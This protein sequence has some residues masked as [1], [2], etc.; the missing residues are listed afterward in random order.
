MIW[1]QENLGEHSE[2]G[3]GKAAYSE[4]GTGE[5]TGHRH[6][7]GWAVRVVSGC[8]SI[9]RAV[10]NWG[11][12]GTSWW[13]GGTWLPYGEICPPLPLQEGLAKVP[14]A[15]CDGTDLGPRADQSCQ[16][17]CGSWWPGGG[18]QT[19]THTPHL[20][21][22]ITVSGTAILQAP[23]SASVDTF[24]CEECLEESQGGNAWQPA[25]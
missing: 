21:S 17:Q 24:V 9:L 10:G 19:H 18:P 3:N 8:G 25:S 11:M 1:P 23:D 15:T 4:V 12:E 16:L 6:R 14:Q 7:R 2:G 5:G 13:G 20:H 22:G